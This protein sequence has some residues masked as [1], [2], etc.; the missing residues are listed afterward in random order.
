[1]KSFGLNLSSRSRDRATKWVRSVRVAPRQPLK[2]SRRTGFLRRLSFI[3]V[4]ALLVASPPVQSYLRAVIAQGIPFVEL[5]CTDF[6][7]KSLH[8]WGN[9][10]SQV[11]VEIKTPGPSG[12]P[13]DFYFHATDLSGTSWISASPEYRGNWTKLAEKGCGALCFDF[14]LFIDGLT[15]GHIGDDHLCTTSGTCPTGT[16]RPIFP[17]LILI[18]DPDGAGGNPPVRAVYRSNT[19]V[20]EDGASNPGWHHLCA[21]VAL[22]ANGNL[23]SNAEGGWQMLD[24]APNSSWNGILANVTDIQFPIDF[25]GNP[26]EEVGY[27]NFCFRDDACPQT[28]SCAT[29]TPPPAV[30]KADGSGGYT[31]TFSVTNK[32][33][34]DVEHI[35]LTPIGGLTLSQQVFETPLHPGQSTTITVDLGNVKP[36]SDS[37]FFVTLMTKDGPCCTVKVCPVL[38]DCCATATARF[39]CDPK[40]AYTGTFTIVN[41]SP[42]TIKNIYL[43]PSGVTLSQTYFAVNL[44]PGQSFTTPV[45]TIKGAKPGRLCFRLS[46]HTEDMQDCCEVEFCI[47]LPECRIHPGAANTILNPIRELQP[48]DLR[49]RIPDGHRRA[50]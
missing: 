39:E 47:V 29:I 38:P 21:P 18:S 19:F 24:G 16:F 31:Y 49:R 26:A 3:A 9:G 32:S 6:N 10:G 22:L 15:D 34:K 45:L 23:P 44:A 28:S 7:D 33:G 20:T 37:C 13:S 41:T 27:D 8:G 17:S 14:R 5:F 42:N 43:Y 50:A 30:C 36:G 40:G 35:L 2:E 11:K 4:L 25:T 1:M 46:M 12:Q 48:F